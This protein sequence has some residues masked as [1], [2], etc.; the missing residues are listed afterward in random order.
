MIPVGSKMLWH[1]TDGGAEGVAII[2]FGSSLRYFG[3]AILDLILSQL[4]PIRSWAAT[5]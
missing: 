2:T 1:S 4:D 3:L 5:P